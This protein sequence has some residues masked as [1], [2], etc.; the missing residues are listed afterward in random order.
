MK[1]GGTSVGT[2]AAM[3]NLKDI[4]LAASESEPVVVV[5][6]ALSGVTNALIEIA[7]KVLARRPIE[8]DVE[9][10][11]A[12]HRSLLDEVI[13]DEVARTE[14][15]SV[16]DAVFDRFVERFI[17]MYD[18][19]TDDA[20]QTKTD[21]VCYGELW[22]SII[23]A[24]LLNAD[25]HYSVNFIFTRNGRVDQQ[26]TYPEITRHFDITLSPVHVCQGF[27]ASDADTC[28][29]TTLGRGGSDYT[30]ALI[31]A[32]LDADSLEIWTDVD[33]FYDSDPRRNPDAKLFAEMTFDQA[34][35]LCDAGAKVI[36]PPTLQPVRDAG[37]PV[38]VKNT[39]NPAA[40]G[41]LIR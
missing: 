31:A 13:P 24:R 5:V 6:S 2:A 34:Q 19:E 20:E 27:I 35:Q 22:S 18:K 39:F 9:Q 36:Y 7:G 11:C 1:F 29:Y 12:R 37:V 4:V 15:R 33:G 10:L 3:L 40:P 28:R 25:L 38:W 32:A 23:V 16:I 14:T 26:A 17:Q 41:T 21:I 30:A 8:A